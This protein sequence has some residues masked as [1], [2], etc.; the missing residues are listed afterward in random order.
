M[1]HYTNQKE[2]LPWTNDLAY[3]IETS[4]SKHQ[5]YDI[6]NTM[7]KALLRKNRIIIVERCH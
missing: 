7:V 2:S 6:V 1:P 5:N 3:F 4:I